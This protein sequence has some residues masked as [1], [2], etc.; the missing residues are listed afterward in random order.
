MKKL[1]CIKERTWKFLRQSWNKR[2]RHIV[3]QNLINACHMLYTMDLDITETEYEKLKEAFLEEI[4]RA[5]QLEILTDKETRQLMKN[6]RC[7]QNTSD[8]KK[9]SFFI[10]K[11]LIRI[12][13]RLGYPCVIC[14]N[15]FPMCEAVIIIL[16][17]AGLFYVCF[18]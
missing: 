15:G 10:R 7:V 12:Q 16:F 1:K 13:S 3:L 11:K 9:K 8:L 6:I 18:H 2:K 4:F 14:I 5:F 17:I